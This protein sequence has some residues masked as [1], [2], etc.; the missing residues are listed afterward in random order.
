V[1]RIDGGYDDRELYELLSDCVCRTPNGPDDDRVVIADSKAL[2]KSNDELQLLER[3]VVTA[4]RACGQSTLAWR[5]IWNT[6]AGMTSEQVTSIPWHFD[7]DERLPLS[8]ETNNID[9]TVSR[10]CAGLAKV[11][12]QLVSVRSCAMFPAEFNELV[13]SCGNK[14]NV[15][16]MRTLELVRYA[17][18]GR[19][20][21][22]AFVFCDKHGGRNNYV[23]V[24]QTLFPDYLVEVRRESRAESIYRWGPKRKR[25][26]FRFVMNGENFLPTALASMVSKYLRELAMRAFN[27]FWLNHVPGIRRTA[28]YPADSR[29][30]KQDIAV[31]QQEL[32]INDHHLWR[33]R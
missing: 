6:V 8:C 7:Y 9:E 18:D 26:E 24:L 33:C 20:A 12:M 22:P 5:D 4:L 32:G 27:A 23:P 14:A 3:G 25:V 13:D 21:E 2:Y 17:L 28:G 31:K 19:P 30:F 10:F 11:G 16:S 1:W 15:L 29:R